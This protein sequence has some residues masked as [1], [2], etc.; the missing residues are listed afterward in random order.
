MLI[1]TQNQ[2]AEDDGFAWLTL[3][4]WQEGEVKKNMITKDIVKISLHKDTVGRI[5]G[6][7]SK[8]EEPYQSLKK[9][10]KSSENMKKIIFLT[11]ILDF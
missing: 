4:R 1:V 9:S 2:A 10:K 11:D 3:C 6:Y 7:I 5:E 8:F